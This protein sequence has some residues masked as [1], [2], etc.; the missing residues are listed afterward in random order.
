MSTTRFLLP[1]ESELLRFDVDVSGRDPVE[2]VRFRVR[3]D[4]DASLTRECRS[5]NNDGE[6]VGVCE[7]VI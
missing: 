2:P 5:D 7:D 3:I 1:G 6:T 4:S